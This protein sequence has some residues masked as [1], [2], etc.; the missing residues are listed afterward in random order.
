MFCGV[1]ILCGL[2]AF[3]LVNTY[4][5]IAKD[6]IN[7]SYHAVTPMDMGHFHN[8]NSVLTTINFL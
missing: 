8:F 2:F 4:P 6:D 3:S 1:M 5:K 7:Y